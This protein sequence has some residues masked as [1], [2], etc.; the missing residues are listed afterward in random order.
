[1]STGPE[2]A[3]SLRHSGLKMETAPEYLFITSPLVWPKHSA[4]PLQNI[5]SRIRCRGMSDMIGRALPPDTKLS[6]LS[7]PL[8]F[9]PS[10]CSKCESTEN[11]RVNK[12]VQIAI[13][14]SG[15]FCS[16][17]SSS[18]PPSTRHCF[19]LETQDA[20]AITP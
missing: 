6:Q 3:G 18:H 12:E 15:C 20:H 14:R 17:P 10:R 4:P 11:S 1:M 8:R 16:S 13:I 5:T 7:S 2:R 9:L 19:F